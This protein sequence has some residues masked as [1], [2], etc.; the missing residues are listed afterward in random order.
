[1]P[2]QSA[3]SCIQPIQV[4]EWCR[5]QLWETD[6][7]FRMQHRPKEQAK[8]ASCIPKCHK[9]TGQAGKKGMRLLVSPCAAASQ[10]PKLP[11]R[12]EYLMRRTR[13]NR[14]TSTIKPVFMPPGQALP[15]IERSALKAFTTIA[16][17]PR[18]SQAA[19]Q[20]CLVDYGAHQCSRS[21]VEAESKHALFNSF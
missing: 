12:A 15:P 13:N 18:S 21:L 11:S 7:Q 14:H 20:A 17:C 3:C 10:A 8:C 4:L 16:K 19:K 2:L 5:E 6:P 9:D 1:M